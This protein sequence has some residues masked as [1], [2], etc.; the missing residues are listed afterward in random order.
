MYLIVILLI[1]YMISIFTYRE[2]YT[3]YYNLRPE[4][5]INK[6]VG[7]YDQKLIKRKLGCKKENIK[8]NEN[9]IKEDNIEEE[10]SLEEED[11]E[12]NIKEDNIEETDINKRFLEKDCFFYDIFYYDNEP[13]TFKYK[14]NDC[15]IKDNLLPSNEFDYYDFSLKLKNKPKVVRNK[16]IDDSYLFNKNM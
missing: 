6:E 16:N 1:T 12:N 15:N 7:I 10:N 8:K 2:R 4:K 9:N 5:K 13:F 11:N 3:N 14:E